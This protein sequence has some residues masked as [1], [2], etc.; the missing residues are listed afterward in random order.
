MTTKF[1]GVKVPSGFEERGSST[2]NGKY[3]YYTAEEING[4]EYIEYEID[5]QEFLTFGTSPIYLLPTPASNEFYTYEYI[6]E[7]LDIS[8]SSVSNGGT[9]ANDFVVIAGESSFR[10]DFFS[11]SD[12][13][14]KKVF[15]GNSF[16]PTYGGTGTVTDGVDT[17]NSKNQTT[18]EEGLVLTTWGGVDNLT[19]TNFVGARLKIWYTL[20]TV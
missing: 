2:A 12:M 10:G 13:L 15:S 6:K 9:L 3:Q 5:G 19:S 7:P 14:S 20:H 11:Y 16:N 17:Y 18:L 4:R 8:Q 1:L